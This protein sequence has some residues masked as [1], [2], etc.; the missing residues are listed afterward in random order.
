M[1]FL[2]ISP[3]FPTIYSHFV[4]SLHDK[5]IKVLGIGDNYF[6]ELNEELKNNLEEYCYVSDLS[7]LDWLKDTVRY[8][9]GKYGDIDYIE[10]NNECWLMNDAELRSYLNIN[11]GLLPLDMERIKYKS[12]MKE[13][14]ISSNAKV[15]R[16]IL[17]S[18]IT[19][20]IDF[21]NEVGFPVF[22][23]PDNGVGAA[24]TYKISNYDELVNFHKDI[25]NEAYIIEEYLDGYIVSFDGISNKKSE[26]DI[27]FMETFPVPIA[28]VVNNDKDLYYFAETNIPEEF[29]R[30]GERVV[31]SFNI[32]KR[33]FHIEFFVLNQD[34]VGLGN[35]GDYI[36]LEV[37]MRCPGGHTPD[38]LSLAL[39]DSFYD[40]YAALI[41]DIPIKPVTIN[42]KVALSVSRKNKHTYKY[43]VEEI[44]NNYKD[45]IKQI[46]NYPP[47][48]ASAMGDTYFFALFDNKKEALQFKDFVLNK[49]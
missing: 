26:V 40:R 7:R 45:N 27:A 39:T 17:S 20:S 5:G 12:K 28:D 1:V 46:G 43:T 29:R 25:R 37:N 41:A 22:A 9:K 49:Y 8:L 18:D 38:L 34:K 23:K 24:K 10:S 21:I 32:S 19:R 4:K 42:N 47:L 36:A 31:K 13:Y 30:L 33:C 6:W 16:Y 48:I 44:K 3:N 11:T 15:A 14:F 35:K 2:F